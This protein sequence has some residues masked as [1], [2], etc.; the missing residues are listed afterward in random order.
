MMMK[1]NN[2]DIFESAFNNNKA[3]FIKRLIKSGQSAVHNSKI[4][5]YTKTL[6]LTTTYYYTVQSK[7][8][9]CIHKI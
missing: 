3:A 9:L 2:F 1:F 6:K 7:K 4:L 5:K 8:G